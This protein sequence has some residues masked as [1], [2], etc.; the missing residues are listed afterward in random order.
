MYKHLTE[1]KIKLNLPLL[2]K[3]KIFGTSNSLLLKIQIYQ[4]NLR[5]VKCNPRI[6]RTYL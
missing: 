4:K 1:Y 2:E 6:G 5:G 3:G